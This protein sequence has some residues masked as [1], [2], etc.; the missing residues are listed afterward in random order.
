MARRLICR[1]LI[2][3]AT[4]FTMISAGALS[5]PYRVS[6]DQKWSS[7]ICVKNYE[8]GASLTEEYSKAERLEG[9]TSVRT[10]SNG[11]GCFPEGQ[12][13]LLEAGMRS[14][15]TG[16]LHSVWESVDPLPEATGRHSSISRNIEDLTGTFSVDRFIQLWPNSTTGS[17]SID[18]LSCI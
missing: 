6:Y 10:Y 11:S 12:P 3:L 18:W 2:I 16:A 13:G 14:N 1:V 4:T 7:E 17:V 8:I 15:A 5:T 9:K